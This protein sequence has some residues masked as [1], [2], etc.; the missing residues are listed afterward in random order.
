MQVLE[1]QCGADNA[2]HL[3]SAERLRLEHEQMGLSAPEQLRGTEQHARSIE[4]AQAMLQALKV[5]HRSV[6]RICAPKQ[7]QCMPR[8]A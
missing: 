5:W 1:R 3:I 4:Q 6:L 8:C 7:P 2:A